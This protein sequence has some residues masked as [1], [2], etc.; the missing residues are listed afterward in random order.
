M[1]S[2]IHPNQVKVCNE[3]YG[4]SKAEITQ[5]R[6]I[7]NAYDAAL[8]AGQGAITVDGIMIDVPVAD[9][10]RALLEFADALANR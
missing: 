8:A 9:R 5:A 7:V 10:S 6:K 1:A 4:P 2:C 3:I